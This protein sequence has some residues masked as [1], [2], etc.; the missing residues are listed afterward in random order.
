L[1]EGLSD[2]AEEGESLKMQRI[3]PSKP[4]YLTME[5]LNGRLKLEDLVEQQNQNGRARVDQLR[6]KFG[7]PPSPERKCFK[8]G[9]VGH[10][11]K[12]CTNR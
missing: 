8:C 11:R 12:D 5:Q 3:Q 6:Q 10:F 4:T 7:T 9:E 2:D 1:D